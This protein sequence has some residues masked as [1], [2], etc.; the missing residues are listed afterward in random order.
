MRGKKFTS[1]LPSYRLHYP[2]LSIFVLKL[3]SIGH[4]MG[5]GMGSDS[6]P[7][8]QNRTLQLVASQF[9]IKIKVFYNLYTE[10]KVYE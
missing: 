8:Y 4:D 6:D 7:S 1:M 5:V 2:G 3:V 10:K 9:K